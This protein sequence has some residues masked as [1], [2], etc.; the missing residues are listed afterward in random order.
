M[1]KQIKLTESGLTEPDIQMLEVNSLTMKVTSMGG[2]P[3]VLLYH[4]FPEL[5]IL[6]RSQIVVLAEAGYK[7]VAPDMR[8]YGKTTA[9]IDVSAYT[10]P[11]R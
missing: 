1:N 3:L 7:A 9:P 4:G 6:W 8:G 2:G 10:I 5:A 11:C